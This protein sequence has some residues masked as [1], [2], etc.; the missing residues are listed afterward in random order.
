[1][2]VPVRTL[3]HFENKPAQK[4]FAAGTAFALVP[5]GWP[6]AFRYGASRPERLSRSRIAMKHKN[7]HLLVGYWSR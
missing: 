3:C 1:M 5:D 4:G 2:K 7:S 6:R